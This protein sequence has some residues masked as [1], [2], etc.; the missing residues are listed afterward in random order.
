M[1]S[2]DQIVRWVG[3]VGALAGALAVVVAT[4]FYLESVKIGQDE[5]G[6]ALAVAVDKLI[7]VVEGEAEAKRILDKGWLELD[8]SGQVRLE[9]QISTLTTALDSQSSV[10]AALSVAL[11]GVIRD[12]ASQFQQREQRFEQLE[13][14]HKLLL[15]S[16]Y[17]MNADIAEA[18]GRHEGHH[19]VMTERGKG[20]D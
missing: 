16:I 15:Q 9:G 14:E 8:Q 5:Q 2:S 6:K 18:I 12:Q 11:G 17:Q 3:I 19:D 13:N 4:I 20:N 10:T 7:A 1:V